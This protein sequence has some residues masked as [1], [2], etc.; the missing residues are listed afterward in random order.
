MN[1]N[2]PLM[3]VEE[4]A[5]YTRLSPATVRWLRHARRGPVASVLGRRVL[6]RR[7]DVDAWIESQRDK[8]PAA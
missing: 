4:V 6:Y 5:E 2:D 7:S 8:Q 3:T 1:S